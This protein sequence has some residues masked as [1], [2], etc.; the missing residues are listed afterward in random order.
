[1]AD[2]EEMKTLKDKVF[3]TRAKGIYFARVPIKEWEWFTKY[4]AEE[5]CDDY[6]L[7]FKAIVSGFMP[8]D[9][10]IIAEQLEQLIAAVQDLQMRMTVIEQNIPGTEEKKITLMGGK[11]IIPPKR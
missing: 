6:G 11:T 7:A 5:W 9:N 1:M 10:T 8:P 2:S 3:N 4:A